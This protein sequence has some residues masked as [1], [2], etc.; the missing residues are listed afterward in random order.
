MYIKLNSSESAGKITLSWKSSK[1]KFTLKPRPP[2]FLLF[3]YLSIFFVLVFSVCHSYFLLLVSTVSV[4]LYYNYLKKKVL[5]KKK[6]YFL[7]CPHS[8]TLLRVKE[9]LLVG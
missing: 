6:T 2:L 7:V 1:Q 5:R 4:E 3:I 8:V 9:R